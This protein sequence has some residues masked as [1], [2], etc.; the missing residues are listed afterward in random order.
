MKIEKIIGRNATRNPA[1]IDA[2]VIIAIQR[3]SFI[4]FYDI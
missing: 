3:F 4:L 2:V 1:K